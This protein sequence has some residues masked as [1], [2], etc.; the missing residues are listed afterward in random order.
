[1]IIR[2]YKSFSYL[3]FNHLN[4]FLHEL[5]YWQDKLGIFSRNFIWP[6]LQDGWNAGIAG[7]LAGLASL[8]EDPSRRRTLALFVFAR[9]VGSL[10]S[11]LARRKIIPTV[12]HFPVIV[13]SIC[14][15]FLVH[16]ITLNRELI[17]AGYLKSLLQ[18]TRNYNVNVLDKLFVTKGDKFISCQEVG[19]HKESCTHYAIRDFIMSLPAFA[20]LYFPIHLVP[21]LIFKRKMFLKR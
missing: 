16:C 5:H 17:Q 8:V 13:F 4:A 3:F 6:F 12:P 1:M 10:L 15:G 20:K 7:G 19:L 18:W 2:T 11:T 14:A 9:A 21:V